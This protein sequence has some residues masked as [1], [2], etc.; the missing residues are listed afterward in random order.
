MKYALVHKISKA[1]LKIQDAEF[2]SVPSD[3]NEAVITDEQ[4]TIVESSNGQLFLFEQKLKQSSEMYFCLNKDLIVSEIRA[5]RNRLL[6]DCDWTQ[7]LD[8]PISESQ[9]LDWANYRQSL[10][11]LPATISD[12]GSI[13]WPTKPE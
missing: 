4:A 13:S 1:I 6:L 5:K 9:K 3:F 11:D 10:R 8:A 2:E 12:D 7:T